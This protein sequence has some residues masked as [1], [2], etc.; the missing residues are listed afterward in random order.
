MSKLV[1]HFGTG[2]L[3]HRSCSDPLLS[4]R[5][6]VVAIYN[7]AV[8]IVVLLALHITAVSYDEEDE[9]PIIFSQCHPDSPMYASLVFIDVFAH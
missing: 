6:P 2:V 1:L 4:S 7:G 8:L 9:Q 5:L 3:T